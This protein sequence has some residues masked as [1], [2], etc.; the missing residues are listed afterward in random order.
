[1]LSLQDC[2][3]TESEK[4]I[5]DKISPKLKRSKGILQR[6]ENYKGATIAIKE[7]ISGFNNEELQKKAW[8]EVVPLMRELKI[9]YEF[10]VELGF[11]YISKINE[12]TIL[13]II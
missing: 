12:N 5:F 9:C 3:P 7:A 10:A 4:L 2:T 13:I 1:M 8:D 11:K 6:L